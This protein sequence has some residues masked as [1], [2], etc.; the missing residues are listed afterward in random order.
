MAIEAV[1][2]VRPVTVPVMTAPG[3]VFEVDEMGV[4]VIGEFVDGP[5]PP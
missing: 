3:V 2:N 4:G 1:E 5:D